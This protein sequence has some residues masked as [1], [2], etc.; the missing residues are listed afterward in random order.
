MLPPTASDFTTATVVDWPSFHESISMITTMITPDEAAVEL[1]PE[2][3]KTRR[4]SVLLPPTPHMEQSTKICLNQVASRLAALVDQPLLEADAAERPVDP[5]ASSDISTSP[6]TP[7]SAL[8]TSNQFS[9]FHSPFLSPNL[10]PHSVNKLYEDSPFYAIAD[11]PCFTLSRHEM[12][13]YEG[14]HSDCDPSNSTNG[15]TPTQSTLSATGDSAC[16]VDSA[17]SSMIITNRWDTL[18]SLFLDSTGPEMPVKETSFMDWDSSDDEGHKGF[19]IGKNCAL[20]GWKSRNASRLRLQLSSRKASGATTPSAPTDGGASRPLSPVW[21]VPSF[22]GKDSAVSTS[23]SYGLDS[24]VSQTS[25]IMHTGNSSPIL[26][27]LSRIR[28]E[29]S[30]SIAATSFSLQSEVPTSG[31]RASFP[32][33]DSRSKCWSATLKMKTSFF[34]DW[35]PSHG[36]GCDVEQSRSASYKVAAKRRDMAPLARIEAAMSLPTRQRTRPQWLRQ[37]SI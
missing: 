22:V 35:N 25:L 26:P 19:R 2:S 13:L 31:S 18:Q 5:T 32:T 20:K 17:E 21:N 10:A 11:S 33:Q 27:A 14:L 34:R 37:Y 9:V 23:S 30:S 29:I 8:D 1:C 28:N 15:N 3:L 12:S 36:D 7:V 24:R 6:R 16:V 4:E